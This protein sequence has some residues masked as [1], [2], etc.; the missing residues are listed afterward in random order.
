M[1]SNTKNILSNLSVAFIAN[2]ISLFSSTILTMVMPKFIGVEQYA[3]YQLYIFYASYIGFLGLGWIEGMYLRY[4]GHFYNTLNKS[5]M[6]KQFRIFSLL[7]TFFGV[8]VICVALFSYFNQSEKVVIFF[9][10]GLCIIIY[11]PRALLHNLLQTTD[12]IKEYSYSIIIEKAVNIG[13]NLFGIFLRKSFFEWYII[14]EL[15]G[16][17]IATTYIFIVCK[18]IV[19]VHKLNVDNVEVKKEIKDNISAGIPLMISNVA[20]ML[21]LGVVRQ[22]I[23][24]GWDIETFGKISLT[25]T[26]SNL[27]MTFINSV[28]LVVFP[29]LKRIDESKLSSYYKILRTILITVT[30]GVLLLY[31]PGKTLLTMWLPNYADSLEYMAILLPICVY[32]S[33]MSLLINTYMKTLRKEKQLLFINIVSVGMSIFSTFITCSLL[34]SLDMAILSIVLLF[35][36]RCTVAEIILKKYIRI[37]IFKDIVGEVLLTVAFIISSWTIGGWIGVMVYAICYLIYIIIRHR[38]IKDSFGIVKKKMV[39]R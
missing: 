18:D 22:A 10:L 28:A 35:A 30:F 25:L 5:I 3:Y 32:E 16:R 11:M 17:L 38:I 13:L 21:V 33:K 23:E 6:I 37:D 4:G 12:K 24:I 8:L 31:Y 29:M 27:L 39:E 7:E 20:S 34:K 9:S 19:F 2:V 1:K 14:S 26:C 15:V 36:I